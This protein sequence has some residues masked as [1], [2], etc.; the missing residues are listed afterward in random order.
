MWSILSGVRGERAE[1]SVRQRDGAAAR[2]ALPVLVRLFLVA[3]VA[4][5]AMWIAAPVASAGT[6]YYAVGKPL[7][8]APKVGHAACFAERRVSVKKGTP[9]ARAFKLGAGATAGSVSPNAQTI[10]PAGGITPFDL[11]T[12]YG[13]NSLTS[14]SSQ[15]VAI[16]DAF[17]DPT[18]EADLQKFDAQYA[19]ATCTTANGCFKKVNQAGASSPLPATDTGWSGEIA[20]DVETVHAVC[21]TCHILLVE[22]NDSSL[23]NLEA[24]ANEAAKLKATEISNSYG[25]AGTPGSSD[26]AAYN[27]PGIVITASTGDDGYYSFDQYALGGV[28]PGLPEFPAAANTVVAVGG[29]SLYL[30]QNATRQSES[31][32]N[33]NGTKDYWEQN[34]FTALGATGGGCST[35]IPA[36]GWQTGLSVWASTACGT[37]RLPA[38]I[39]SDADYLTGIDTYD[40]TGSTGWST[41]GGTSFSSPTIAAMFALAGGAHGVSYPALTLYGHNGSSAALYDVT[42]GGNG[43]CGGEGAAA[44]GNVNN[45]GLGPLDCDYNTAGTA[46][47]A[48]DRACDALAGYDGPTGLGTPKGLGVFAKTG[49]AVTISGPTSIAHGT[50]GTWKA[51]VTD[52]FPGGHPT[53][54]TFNWGD[55]SANTVVSSTAFSSSQTHTYAA[56]AT[57]TI[58]VTVKDNYNQTGTKTYPVT[59]S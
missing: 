33:D 15:T 21:Q 4:L 39:S 35:T 2:P 23:A 34:L 54:Y 25:G 58:T 28:D 41:I 36:Q 1:P 31:V 51:A 7:C 18:I 46:I 37:H 55:G 3:V 16:V 17:N 43:Y 24:A 5:G 59:V 30:G 8:K 10:G 49:P 42:V 53:T 40:T 29:T 20:L 19:L 27:H 44:C 50:L 6:T 45:L 22:A 32:W 47:A 12:A 26:L 52:P 38:D 48:G 13:F 11:A 57:R 14:A 9:G 56:A